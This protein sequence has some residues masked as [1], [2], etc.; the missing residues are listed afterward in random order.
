[1]TTLA[2]VFCLFVAL[3]AGIGIFSPPRF[4]DIVKRLTS[5][6]GFYIIA[7][8]RIAFGATLYLAAA[9]S[10]LPTFVE[11]TGIVVFV[12]GIVTPFFSHARYRKVIEWWSAGGE[13][14]I[15]IWAGCATLFVLLLAYILLP[16]AVFG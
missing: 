8:L 6:Q 13:M 5:L 2:I 1:M 3:F 4:L 11:I 10:R 9:A 14:Y 16:H 12:S 15:R 7:I